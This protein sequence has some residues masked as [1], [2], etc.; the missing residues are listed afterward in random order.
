MLFLTF[1]S[2]AKKLRF[3][4][5]PEIIR[6]PSLPSDRDRVAKA[7]GPDRG[8]AISLRATQSTTTAL[9]KRNEHTWRIVSGPRTKSAHTHPVLDLEQ[10]RPSQPACVMHTNDINVYIACVAVA[11]CREDRD[12]R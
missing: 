11:Q 7:T 9:E 12:N 10:G 8:L 2:A 6:G 1:L 3:T 4:G 5:D